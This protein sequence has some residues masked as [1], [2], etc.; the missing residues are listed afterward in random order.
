[1]IKNKLMNQNDQIERIRTKL[2][3][4][5]R[6]NIGQHRMFST[7]LCILMVDDVN[8]CISGSAL[9]QE[10]CVVTFKIFSVENSIYT[11]KIF[12]ILF[13]LLST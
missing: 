9:I 2:K 13:Y 5:K 6:G 7:K 8:A 11:I 12:N 1:M 4:E 10:F 3:D